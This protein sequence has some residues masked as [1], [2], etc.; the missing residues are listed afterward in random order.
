MEYNF[1]VVVIGA[2]QAGLS[3]GYHLGQKGV[4]YTLLEE[5]PR[6]GDSWR[7]R[8]QSL[9]LFTPREYSALP[10]LKMI[11][12]PKGYP[13][14]DEVADYL[15]MYAEHFQ[16]PVM[17]NT[18]VQALQA[19]P[20]GFRIS[21]SRGDIH[22]HKVVVAIG[23]FQ[24]PFTPALSGTVAD[25]VFQIHAADYRD[26][27]PL[28]DGAV[29]VVGAGNSGV[30]IAQELTEKHQVILSVGKEMKF[31]PKEWMGRSIF[32]WMDLTGVAKATVDSKLG[33]FIR[34]NDPIIGFEVKAFLKSGAIQLRPRTKS[35]NGNEIV[36]EDGSSC[37]VQNIIWATGY[38]SDYRWIKLS[39]LF[40][41]DGNVIHQR[42][43]T[44]VP[45]IFF[46]GLSWQYRRGSA[47]LMGVG[48]DAE[49]LAGWM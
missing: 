9:E 2:G 23:A 43:K 48:E 44:P 5:H 45:G 17:L 30:Q 22:A 47:L 46:L 3:M 1:E 14:K 8:Y 16:M 11:G 36:F 37:E 4:S 20:N 41:E 35:A 26:P 7:N 29:L 24:K 32:K 34:K 31:L 12:E 40:D 42:G 15:E 28:R 27:S 33:R 21:T 6:V 19:V 49:Y 10:G 13:T 25:S 39:G 38:R 18:S